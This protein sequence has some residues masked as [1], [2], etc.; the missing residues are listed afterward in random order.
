[1]L[2]YFEFTLPCGFGEASRPPASSGHSPAK[3]GAAARWCVFLVLLPKTGA[4]TNPNHTE[5]RLT[6]GGF[7]GFRV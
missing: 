5:T 6:L 4:E 2:D 1:M 7:Y 3:A